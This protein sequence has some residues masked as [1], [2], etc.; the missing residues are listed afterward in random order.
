M[1]TRS[2]RGI[3]AGSWPGE[4]ATSWSAHVG[5]S[6]SCRGCGCLEKPCQGSVR[7]VPWSVRVL[8]WSVRLLHNSVR[9]LRKSVRSLRKSAPSLHALPRKDRRWAASLQMFRWAF[10]ESRERPQSS[11]RSCQRRREQVPRSMRPAPRRGWLL[12]QRVR[13]PRRRVRPARSG[14]RRNRGP[15]N[16]GCRRGRSLRA[17][18]RYPRCVG[19]TV[20][21]APGRFEHGC[22]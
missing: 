13:S 1:R 10:G 3:R 7:E 16:T 4:E 9:S 12:A 15:R 8:P 14:P 6:R 5:N 19:G 21:R 2:I 20:D 17:R 22:H 11:P 18:F